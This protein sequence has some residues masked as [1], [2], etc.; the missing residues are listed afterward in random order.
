[1]KTK[2]RLLQIRLQISAEMGVKLT[3]SDMGEIIKA[4]QRVIGRYENQEGQPSLGRA[5]D[6]AARIS[7][8][9]GKK[10]YVE[11]IFYNA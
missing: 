7:R 10:Y 5:I 3:Q 11:D 9:T 4:D 6:I 1:V 8:Y 2:N